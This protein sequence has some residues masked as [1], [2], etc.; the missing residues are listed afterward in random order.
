MESACCKSVKP[1]P[2]VTHDK[3]SG[4]PIAVHRAGNEVPQPPAGNGQA[5]PAGC[6]ANRRLANSWA[7]K[8]AQRSCRV[9]RL[10]QDGNLAL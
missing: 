10:F 9:N 4:L 3:A 1:C 2:P 7:L 8:P 6:R 5:V